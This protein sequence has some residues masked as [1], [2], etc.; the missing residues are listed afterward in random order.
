MKIQPCTAAEENNFYI[1]WLKRKIWWHHLEFFL[2]AEEELEEVGVHPTCKICPRGSCLTL[3]SLYSFLVPSWD[4]SPLLSSSCW[5]CCSSGRVSQLLPF[6]GLLS[7]DRRRRGKKADVEG[8]D[9]KTQEL[10]KYCRA[11]SCTWDLLC[12][13]DLPCTFQKRAGNKSILPVQ[14]AE[15]NKYFS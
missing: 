1:W 11:I 13:S 10:W 7:I 2:G 5:R 4:D 14:K 12:L 15:E 9:I 8:Q 6:V 3:L